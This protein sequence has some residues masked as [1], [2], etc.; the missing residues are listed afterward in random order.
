MVAVAEQ[1]ERQ[2]VF[3][4]EFPVLLRRVIRD[5]DN[6][7]AEFL[8]FVPAVPQLVCFERSTG[9]AGLWIEEEQKRP[10]L[11]IGARYRGA[12]LGFEFEIDKRLSDRNH[13]SSSSVSDR[14]R[15]QH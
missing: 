8:E 9:G 4:G 2:S 11:E 13:L 15:H 7:D 10:P 3:L 12:V 14:G 6:F 1:A 5:T